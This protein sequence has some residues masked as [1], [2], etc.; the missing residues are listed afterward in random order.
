ML[1]YVLTLNGVKEMKIGMAKAIRLHC[2]DCSGFYEADVRNCELKNCPLYPYRMGPGR[3]TKKKGE[4][5]RTDAVKQYC[6]DCMIGDQR[7]VKYCVSLN[8]ALFN[9][10][11]CNTKIPNTIIEPSKKRQ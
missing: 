7:E 11:Q 2:L 10:R 4:R 5:K 1:N 9:F 3:S 8:C 6:I